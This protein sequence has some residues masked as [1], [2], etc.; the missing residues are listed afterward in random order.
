MNKQAPSVGRI[1]VMVGFALSCF[2]LLLYLWLA[3]GGSTPLKPKGYRFET[4]FGEATQ[5]AKEA[6]VRISGV[7]V[8]K[9]KDIQPDK[10]T[11]RST[12]VIELQAR[13]A[14]LAKDAKA[15]LRQKTLLGETYVELT[16]GD[17]RR[18]GW[19]PENGHLSAARVSSTVELDEIFRAFDPKTRAEFQNW[20]QTF[21]QTTDG[22][23]R[24][25]NDALGNLPPFASDTTTLLQILESQSGAVR[26]LVSN[27]GVVFNALSER[28]GQLQ[29]LIKNSNTVF[30]TTAKRNQELAQT[31]QA[32]PTFEK[33]SE[34]TVKR[35]TTFAKNTDPLISQL[36]PAARQLSPTL[37]ELSA[38]APDLK[39]LF[40]DLDPAITASKKGLPATQALLDELKPFLGQLDP[41]LTQLNPILDFLGRYKTELGPFFAN[42]TAATQAA[43]TPPGGGPSDPKVHYLRTS[44]PLNLENLAAYPKRLATNRNNPYPPSGSFNN[45]ANGLQVFDDRSCSAGALP[46]LAGGLGPISTFLGPSLTEQ[47]QKVLGTTDTSAAAEIAPPCKKQGPF[48][49]NGRTTQF[50]QVT[51]SAA[52]AKGG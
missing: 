13:Y 46:T 43:S 48:T 16:P 18:A 27:T 52:G 47:L 23:A 8:G 25:I 3:F 5:L 45:L 19:V 50:P 37:Q 2:G 20:I 26:K 14:P 41:T 29:G 39:A 34:R 15:I 40:R 10:A 21:A 28:D 9:V 36:R 17:G 32:L 11:G 44:N 1:L 30:S 4:S 42:S 33:E 6:D 24:D 31:F 12:A 38:T 49:V 35:L 7:S 22:R 51:A